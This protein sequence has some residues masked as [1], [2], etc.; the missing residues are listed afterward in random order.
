MSE[1]DHKQTLKA[2]REAR[3]S[4]DAPENPFYA[5]FIRGKGEG[6]ISCCMVLLG[7]ETR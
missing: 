4:K 2:M 7:M 6:Q 3:V 1:E 5:D